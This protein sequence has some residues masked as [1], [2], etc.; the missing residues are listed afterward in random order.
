MEPTQE[1]RHFAGDAGPP[2]RQDDGWITVRQ[3]ADILECTRQHVRKLILAD[4]IT[5][6]RPGDH[7]WRLDPMSVDWYR[8]HRPK[9]GPRPRT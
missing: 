6:Y 5:A 9:P 3:A 2:G 1:R 8:D 7:E 4:R